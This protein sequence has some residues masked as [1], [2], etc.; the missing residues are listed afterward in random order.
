M[1]YISRFIHEVCKKCGYCF[2]SDELGT[3]CDC[4]CHKVEEGEY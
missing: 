2:G 3:V 4:I 1:K